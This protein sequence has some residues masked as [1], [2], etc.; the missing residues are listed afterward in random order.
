MPQ[1]C[2][3]GDGNQHLCA[4]GDD[5]L[6][7]TGEGIQ[8]GSSFAVADAVLRG[9]FGSD[10]IG[11]ND[12]DGIIGSSDIHGT[13]QKPHTKLA[14]LF[15][16][17]YLLDAAK[18]RLKA[19]VF[20]D[21]GADGGNQDS[22]HGGLEHALGAGAHVFQQACCGD[23]SGGQHDDGSGK[24]A[25]EQYHKDIDADNTADKYQNIGNDLNKI[26]FLDDGKLL[27]GGIEGNDENDNEGGQCGRERYLKV[28]AEFIFHLAALAMVVSLMKE[29]LSP[30]IAPPMTDAT[31]KGREKPVAT[32]N[33]AAIG[34][35]RV[36]VPTEVPMASETKQLTTKR[37]TTE[38]CEGT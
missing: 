13:N 35:I 27:D 37:M 26:V 14:A 29:R 3:S 19:A 30:N 2:Y 4:V 22:D 9:H 6:E 8:D 17:E 25:N 32:A 20:P 38:Y 12:G 5:A 31:Q 36:M 34:V 23:F 18:Q 7:D 33:G 11:H 24:D 21:E 28:F 15:A 1:L 10:G 16:A